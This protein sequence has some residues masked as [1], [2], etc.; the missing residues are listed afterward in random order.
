MV[1]LLQVCILERVEYDDHVYV[2]E[3]SLLVLAGHL[4]RN[5]RVLGFVSKPIE[6]DYKPFEKP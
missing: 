5:L 2:W 1:V 6:M 4:D 3:V